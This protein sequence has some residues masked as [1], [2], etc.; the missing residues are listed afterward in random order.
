MT[1][2][3]LD[4]GGNAAAAGGVPR[5]H[6]ASA[7]YAAIPLTSILSRPSTLRLAQERTGEGITGRV[8]ARRRVGQKTPARGRA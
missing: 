4:A 5:L 3:R 8:F 1:S 7:R 6:Q 2:E